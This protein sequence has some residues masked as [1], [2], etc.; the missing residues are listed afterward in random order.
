MS[1]IVEDEHQLQNKNEIT[2]LLEPQ[3]LSR[4]VCLLMI[5]ILIES[6]V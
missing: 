1:I 4:K 2:F 3:S 5:I 6:K